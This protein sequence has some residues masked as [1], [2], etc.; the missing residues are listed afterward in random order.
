MLVTHSQFISIYHPISPRFNSADAFPLLDQ[1][2]IESTSGEIDLLINQLS[3]AIVTASQIKAWTEKDPSLSRVHHQ[4]LHGW[5]VTNLDAPYFNRHDEFS[6]TNGCV[7][8]VSCVIVPPP[9]RD[10]I[11]KQLHDTY[12]DIRV[13]LALVYGGQE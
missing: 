10:I 5:T 7:L 1:P 13:W 2:A 8:W 9:G 6:V 12:P 3:E 11:L 4:V